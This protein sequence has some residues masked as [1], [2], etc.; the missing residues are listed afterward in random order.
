MVSAVCGGVRVVSP[1]RA[2]RARGRLAVLRGQARAGSSGCAR[3]LD[4]TQVARRAARPG[5]RLQRDARPTRTSGARRR[6]T[7]APTCPSPE[8][9]ALAARCCDWGLADAYRDRHA[10]ARPLLVV[11]LPGRHVPPQRGDADRPPLRDGAGG[12]ARRRGPRSTARRA[13]AR[14]PRRTTRRSSST[15]T[16]PG[17]RST[18]AG[19]TPRHG[20]P[21][22]SP[23][24]GR[25]PR[26]DP[27]LGRHPSR[28]V[29]RASRAAV[30]RRRLRPTR[31]PRP[32]RRPPGRSGAPRPGS[33]A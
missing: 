18:R 20:S 15:S 19:R 33:P 12:R 3:W 29:P 23:R 2:E 28:E 6:R 7:A 11:G 13:R 26:P 5:R 17:A 1:L 25:T 31:A 8:R 9:E 22:G 21:P 32:D 27:S 30:P 16:S 4:E 24:G 14:P 10:G